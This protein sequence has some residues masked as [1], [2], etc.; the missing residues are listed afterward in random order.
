MNRKTGLADAYSRYAELITAQI[1]AVEAGDLE[2]FATF[3]RERDAIARSIDSIHAQ[4]P[5]SASELARSLLPQLE[6]A[7][8][9]DVRL[10][11]RLEAIHHES[12]AGAQSIHRNRGAIR[13]YST[14][15]EAGARFDLSF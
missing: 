11:E 4:D 1:S 2:A 10:R 8:V 12:L 15:A 14:P 5:G 3:T 9:L 6:A 7:L 13:S